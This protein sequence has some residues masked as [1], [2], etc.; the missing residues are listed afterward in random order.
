M[1]YKI[2]IDEKYKY[3]VNEKIIDEEI[4][5]QELFDYSI[6]DRLD[7]IGD[8]IDWISEAKGN[9]KQLMKDDLKYLINLPDEFI[10]SSISTNE[11]TALSDNQQSF[12]DL[13]V[14][15]LKLNKGR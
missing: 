7:L 1:K 2:S 12:D 15:L 13:C 11:Y 14:D 3:Y 6:K 10:F 9:D 8:L 4:F 5:N